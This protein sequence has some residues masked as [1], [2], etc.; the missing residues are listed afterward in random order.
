M[1]SPSCIGVLP[2]RRVFVCELAM[3]EQVEEGLLYKLSG[4]SDKHIFS[5]IVNHHPAGQQVRTTGVILALMI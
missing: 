5:L 3:C 4:D 1:R 2:R